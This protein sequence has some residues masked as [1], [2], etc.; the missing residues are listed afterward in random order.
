VSDNR[1]LIHLSTQPDSEN[2]CPRIQILEHS[3][4]LKLLASGRDFFEAL[5]Y[6]SSGL[7]SQIVDIESIQETK[8]LPIS[9]HGDDE[10]SRAIAFLNELIY[11][12]YGRKW[13]PKRI[14]RL[15]Q[16]ST[17]NCNTLEGFVTGEPLDPERHT[18]KLDIKAITYHEFEIS[19]SEGMTTIQF[20]CD[21]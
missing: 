11:L 20:V 16:C 9:A 13:L 4:D 10:S 12:I 5:A 15:T 14:M 21:L 1:E 17:K 6:A 8:K 7:I 2:L 19:R 18:L 3:G